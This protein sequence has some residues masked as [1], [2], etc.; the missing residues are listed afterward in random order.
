MTP[1]FRAKIEQGRI[2]LYPGEKLYYDHVLQSLEGQNVHIAIGK[3]KGL[4]TEQQMRYYFGVVIKLIADHTGHDSDYIHEFLKDK[5]APRQTRRVHGEI[6]IVAGCTHS[7]FKEN[8]F[9]DYVDHIRRWASETLELVIP[10][11]HQVQP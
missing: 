11:P 6:R 5:F 9:A 1:K 2:K 3:V 8:F 10:D 7:L 4:R